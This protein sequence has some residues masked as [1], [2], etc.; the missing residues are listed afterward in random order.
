MRVGIV[1]IDLQGLVE[2]C[3]G[4]IDLPQLSE[5]DAQVVPG[6]NMAGIELD[7]LAKTFRSLPL[8]IQGVQNVAQVETAKEIGPAALQRLAIR[9][10]GFMQ[11]TRLLQIAASLPPAL[12]RALIWIG[13]DDYRRAVAGKIKLQ[14]AARFRQLPLFQPQEEP[15]IAFHEGELGQRL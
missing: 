11:L 7:G 13:V 10:G 12:R 8:L 2:C 9:S 6:F 4:F 14:L 3:Y 1:R 5:G 15:S